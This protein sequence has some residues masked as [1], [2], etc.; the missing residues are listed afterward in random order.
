MAYRP[1]LEGRG[2]SFREAI[3]V[4]GGLVWGDVPV[5]ISV[6]TGFIPGIRQC[7]ESRELWAVCVL[8]T[9]WAAPTP[10]DPLE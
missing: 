5:L 4:V 7:P 6:G 9:L 8:S 2:V 10:E 1:P 3:L